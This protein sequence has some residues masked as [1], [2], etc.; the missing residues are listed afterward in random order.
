MANLGAIVGTLTGGAAGFFTAKKY[1]GIL[2]TTLGVTTYPL[3]IGAG[4]LAL[5]YVGKNLYKSK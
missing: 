3:M 5:G 1:Y 2:S 4:A